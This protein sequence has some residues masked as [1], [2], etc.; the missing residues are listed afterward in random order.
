MHLICSVSNSFMLSR[1]VTG[2]KGLV[3]RLIVQVVM[4]RFH[5]TFAALFIVSHQESACSVP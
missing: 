5:L 3:S 1:I 2:S 4:G